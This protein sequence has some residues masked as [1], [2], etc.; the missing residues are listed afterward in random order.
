MAKKAWK[1]LEGQFFR[2]DVGSTEAEA[3]AS[4]ESNILYIT[5][6]QSIVMN[7]DVVGRGSVSG[8][9]SESYIRYN[10]TGGLLETTPSM[11]DYTY[12]IADNVK[13]TIDKYGIVKVS[14][15]ESIM[16]SNRYALISA[17]D[18]SHWN[19]KNLKSITN[20][21]AGLLY[22]NELDLSHIDISKVSSLESLFKGMTYLSRLNIS[23]WDT[24]NV[25]YFSN[26]FQGCTSLEFL[27]LLSFNLMSAKNA[28]NMSSLHIKS[29]LLGRDFFN[30]PNIS[31]I[32]LNLPDWT[33]RTV[34][35]SLNINLY[36][37]TANSQPNLK[38]TLSEE[39]K[40]ALSDN[41]KT[42]LTDYGYTLA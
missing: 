37:R 12:I 17:V 22:V 31:S 41:A 36:N 5:T 15:D 25:K 18:L 42:R 2:I 8:G 16:I 30:A 3:L 1:D 9:D 29:L 10:V 39:T 14:A 33:D 24:R 7:G 40:A 21:F 6:E 19:P 32:T 34:N 13:H 27:N 26:M 4:E 20:M 38:I 11:F 28:P 35:I 23:T